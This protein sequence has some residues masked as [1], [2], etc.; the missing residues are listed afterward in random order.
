MERQYIGARYVPKFYEGTNGN[1]WDANASYEPLTIVTY[2]NSSYTSKKPVPATIGNPADNSDYWVLTGDYNGQMGVL[3]ERVLSLE[4]IVGDNASGLVKEVNDLDET[5]IKKPRRFL[6]WDS[7]GGYPNDN[8]SAK[9]CEILGIEYEQVSP[10]TTGNHDNRY[11]GGIG[12]TDVNG[13]GTFTSFLTSIISEISEPEKIDEII[14]LG[15]ANDYGNNIGNITTGISTFV[16]YVNSV[17]PNAKIKIG[18][19]SASRTSRASIEAHAV[20]INGYRNCV[21]YGAEY[22]YNTEFIMHNKSLTIDGLHPANN[23]SVVNSIAYKLANAITN[24]SCSVEYFAGENLTA[25]TPTGDFDTLAFTVGTLNASISNGITCYSVFI[26]GTLSRANGTTVNAQNYD[27][28]VAQLSD[29]VK[30]CV[31]RNNDT[32]PFIMCMP[33]II[34]AYNG[35]SLV[36]SDTAY[37]YINNDGNLRCRFTFG[38]TGG[39]VC[40][41]IQFFISASHVCEP[42][43]VC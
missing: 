28:E 34:Y 7:Y 21:N 33:V 23:T 35:S 37:M 40:D 20:A 4:N 10:V 26:N 30:M 3:T 39:C 43:V 31:G 16:T 42:S 12:F 17:M 6:L 14:V 29:S 5:T 22:L 19:L 41:K 11:T 32:R 15:G 2:L 27:F 24:G 18:C 13:Q 8:L 38:A 36:K 9:L 25:S 1:N